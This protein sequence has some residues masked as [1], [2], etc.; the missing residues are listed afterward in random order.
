[1][2]TKEKRSNG[3]IKLNVIK[4]NISNTEQKC[5]EGRIILRCIE[6]IFRTYITSLILPYFS[7]LYI[8]FYLGN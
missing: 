8:H 5:M 2:L 6:Y 7:K 4:W 1:M 3:K